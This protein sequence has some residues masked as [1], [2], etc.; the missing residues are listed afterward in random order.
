MTEYDV[1]IVGAGPAGMFAAEALS[2][3]QLKVLIVD[4]GNDA[5]E[6]RCKMSPESG[7]MHCSPCDIMCGVGGAGTFSDGTLNLRPDIG[8][9]LT[10]FVPNERA[11]ELVE[12][13][14][15]IFLRYGAPE[16]LS[17]PEG[18]E[19]EEIE[20]RAASVGAVFI[21]IPQRHI[22]SDRAPEVIH[23]FKSALQERGVEFRLNTTVKNLIVEGGVCR[24]VITSDGQSIWAR[25]VVLAPGRIGASWVDELATTHGIEAAYGPIDVGVRV[26]VPS[27][28]MDPITR[29]NRDPKFHIRTRRYDDF[30]RTFCTNE[31]GFVV[32]EEYEGFVATNGHSLKDRRSEN[33]NF[34]FLVRV[35][36]TEPLENTTKYG[37]SI[38][39]LATTIGGGKPVL[40]R[41]GDLRRGRRSTWSRLKGNPVKGTLSD[42]TPGDISMALPHRIVMDIIEGLEVLDRII[43][44]VASDSVLLYAPEIKFYAMRLFVDEHMQTSIKGL[45]AAGDGAGLSRDIVNAAATGLLAGRGILRDEA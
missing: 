3:S 41:M 1:V 28:V 42:V 38:A 15:R 13:V 35:N 20:R 16:Q 43:P 30:V 24:G 29:I 18:R 31:H 11:W 36:L 25:Y 21:P 26:E 23:R 45:Y 4:M 40:Q 19:L 7:C 2:E 6:R 27:I 12:E 32:K 39:K 5:L 17:K 37:R 10:E 8:G 9:D 34:A 33:T 14:D 44:G 22:G